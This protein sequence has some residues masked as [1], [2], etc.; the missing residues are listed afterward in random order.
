MTDIEQLDAIIIGTGQGGKPLAGALAEAGWNAAIIER[1]RVGG[2]CVVRGCTPTKTMLA[3]ARVAHLVGRAA[4]YGVRTGDVSVDLE[5]VRGRKRDIVDSWS[6]GSQRGMERHETLELIFGTARFSGPKTVAV[7]LNEGGTRRLTADHIFI[8]VGARNRIP[9]LPGLDSVDYL[10]STSVM[11]LA[12]VPE[13]LVV[14]GGGFIGLEFG[15]MFRRFGS[16]VTIVE[17]DRLAGR[18]DEDV[19]EAIEE[20]FRGEGIGVLTGADARSVSVV[21]GGVELTVSV[22]GE[23]RRIAGTHLLV[24]VG[25]VP[26]SDTLRPELAGIDVDE[27]GNIVVNDRCETGAE[28][29]WALGDVTGAPPFTHVSYDDYRIIRENLLEG[30]RASREGRL[31]PYVLF[32]DPQLGRVGLSEHEAVAAGHDVRI[33]KLP[34]SRV[35]RAMETDETRGFM[36][37]VVDAETDQILGAAILGIEGGEVMTVIQMAMMGGLPWTTLRDAVIAHPTLSESLN[38]LFMTL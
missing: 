30:G 28:G 17:R 22:R 13:H 25:V 11:E 33:A 27:R 14:L 34:M 5:V 20:I 7:E 12:E 31:I 15:Q 29:V 21:A 35:A 32:T 37:A 6:A 16:D 26:N 36:K 19:S 38:S 24:S 23:E 8:N 1:D 10:T 4:D 18:E 9:P 3:S 2:T